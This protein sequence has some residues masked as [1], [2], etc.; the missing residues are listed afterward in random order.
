MSQSRVS[1]VV[2]GKYLPGKLDELLAI[3]DG[4]SMPDHVR[5]AFRLPLND[6]PVVPA[7]PAASTPGATVSPHTVLEHLIRH[8]HNLSYEEAGR[9]LGISPRNL[10]RL[11][12]RE[13]AT[14]ADEVHPTT[15]RILETAYGL[16]T[17]VLLQPWHPDVQLAVMNESTSDPVSE[18]VAE[19]QTG[20][21]LAN[22][23]RPSTLA[24][25][26]KSA[27]VKDDAVQR[28]HLLRDV[29]AVASVASLSGLRLPRRRHVIVGP[30]SI[31]DTVRQ[32][33][34]GLDL[35]IS[36]NGLTDAAIETWEETAQRLGT[37]TRHRSNEALLQE[38]VSDFSELQRHMARR[39]P[40]SSL[41]RLT[42]VTAQMAGLMSLT[43]LKAGAIAESRSWA[44]TARA[45]ADDADEPSTRAWVRAQ[46]AYAHF[47]SNNVHRA[48]VV[49][50]EA[51][52]AAS[53][54]PCVGVALAAALEARACAVIGDAD[55][56]RDALHCA[57]TVL[58]ALAADEQTS[59]AFGYN[60]A[61]LRFHEGNAYTH[62][63]D[64][65]RAWQAQQRALD[66]YP[67]TDYTDRALI[68]L[69]RAHCLAYDGD[70]SLASEYATQALRALRPDQRSGL[71]NDRGRQI[72][73]ILPDSSRA[74][75]GRR[76]LN[77]ILAD[78][79]E[80]GH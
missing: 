49:A 37:D 56:V 9:R 58:D 43:L 38:L 47:Y 53:G 25:S 31:L 7:A 80:P 79:D 68:H 6:L 2:N 12:R 32:L 48:I 39:Q 70:A 67:S 19:R 18:P 78:S 5:Q 42:L 75:P 28:R 61:Q 17:E 33:R 34:H 55:G 62:L 30:Q 63:H 50:R 21:V 72:L 46:E 64:T 69:D 77:D 14:D 22:I 26:P 8:R 44:R 29:T 13:R 10:A 41:R 65:A 59:S 27:P 4:L 1:Q 51:Q 16:P 11:A 36:E 74:L 66:L 73:A 45:A 52:A 3:A 15:R 23:T 35:V 60:E 40:L 76:D 71:I 24:G 20:S 57:T 54:R